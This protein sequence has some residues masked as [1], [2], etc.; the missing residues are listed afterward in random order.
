MENVQTEGNT[1][2]TMQGINN[3]VKKPEHSAKNEND[4]RQMMN[5]AKKNIDIGKSNK[6]KQSNNRSEWVKI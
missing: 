4:M 6:I 3:T 1:L 5:K 2:A